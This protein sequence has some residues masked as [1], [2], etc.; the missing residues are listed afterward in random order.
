MYSGEEERRISAELA[1][2]KTTLLIEGGVPMKPS[3]SWIFIVTAVI[4]AVLIGSL[5]PVGHGQPKGSPIQG[6]VQSGPHPQMP[7]TLPP[8]A[9]QKIAA[10]MRDIEEIRLEI[11][12]IR[13]TLS[14]QGNAAVSVSA[15]LGQVE[16]RITQVETRLTQAES[17]LASHETKISLLC[18]NQLSIPLPGVKLATC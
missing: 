1:Y 16:T 14:E 2:L 6:P 5:A 17:K 10:T 13:Q 11:R 18:K 4:A 8:E 7:Q 3:L 15:R 9:Q 12:A